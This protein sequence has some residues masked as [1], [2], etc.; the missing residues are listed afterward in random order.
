MYL[1]AFILL[2]RNNP[3]A[4]KK[5]GTVKERAARLYPDD[6]D[7]YMAYKAPCIAE[8]YGLCGLE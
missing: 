6:M 5:Y 3:Q 8:L 7:R 4:A 1:F 2:L